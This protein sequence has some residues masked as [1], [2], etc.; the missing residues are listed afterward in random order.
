MT[1]EQLKNK[2]KFYEDKKVEI[3][4]ADYSDKVKAEVDAF[5]VEKEQ[6]I[7]DFEAKTSK[8]YEDNREEELKACNHYI[9]IIDILIADE[10]SAKEIVSSDETANDVVENA[11]I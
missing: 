2:K 10:E 5:R 8:K 11:D 4:E 7:A 9:E 3:A 6:E 1:D